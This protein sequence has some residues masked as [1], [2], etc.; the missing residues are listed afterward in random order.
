MLELLSDPDAWVSL[1]TLTFLEIILG[2][3]NIVFISILSERLPE[4]Q[5]QKARQIG[6]ALALAG[7]LGLLFS[8]S[9]VMGLKDPFFHV[10]GHG[11]SGRDLILL[12]GG[13]FLLYKASTE[14][15][16]HVEGEEHG[17]KDGAGV[18]TFRSAITQILILDIVFSLDSVIT[19]VGM[20]DH[21]PIMVVA[22][23]I[24]VG[25]MLAFAKRIS[26]FIEGHPSIKLLALAFLVMVGAMLIADAF[27]Y[28]VPKGYMYFAIAFS[29]S[30][31]MLNIRRRK[32]STKPVGLRRLPGAPEGEM[33]DEDLL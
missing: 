1:L 16:H 18:V 20:A 29:L 3:D 28:H 32:K 4:E 25:V 17:D 5:R 13:L 6:L 11:I 15:F 10:F 12:G 26:E 2:I 33:K 21:I 7:R 8:I 30:I 9:W 27:G 24:A 14:I 22:M 23:V 31:E 19:A